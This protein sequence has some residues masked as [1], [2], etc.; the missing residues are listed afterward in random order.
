MPVRF[1]T[2]WRYQSL[3]YLRSSVASGLQPLRGMCSH[4]VCHGGQHVS[5]RHKAASV[6]GLCGCSGG[7]PGHVHRARQL[8]LCVSV[9]AVL[10]RYT[11]VACVGLR[12]VVYVDR[13]YGPQHQRTRRRQTSAAS[14]NDSPRGR[15]YLQRQQHLRQPKYRGRPLFPAP[16]NS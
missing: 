14:L 9:C 10:C 16:F 13:S 8:L 2:K 12:W 11:L 6:R 1:D 5:N 3:V 15:K 4:K 7:D